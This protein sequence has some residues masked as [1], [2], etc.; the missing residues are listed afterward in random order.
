[1]VQA[2]TNLT[3]GISRVAEFARDVARPQPLR[4]QGARLLSGDDTAEISA[5]G[6]RFSEP[7]GSTRI[8]TELVVR[9]RLEIAG[10]GYLTPEKLEVA[11]QRLHEQLLRN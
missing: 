3:R 10:G 6:A 5:A 4:P 8:R 11:A 7:V 1:M 9:L 2:I